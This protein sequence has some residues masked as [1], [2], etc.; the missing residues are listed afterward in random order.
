MTVA[1]RIVLF[2]WS[3]PFLIRRRSLLRHPCH[4]PHLSLQIKVMTMTTLNISGHY[5]RLTQ[6]LTP[7]P[8]QIPLHPNPPFHL[9]PHLLANMQT[10]WLLDGEYCRKH[11]ESN[12]WSAHR[13][14]RKELA[15]THS[16]SMSRSTH[17]GSS[18]PLA[19]PS[20]CMHT[21]VKTMN[22][23]KVAYAS[24]AKG[25]SLIQSFTMCWPK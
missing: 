20:C 25:C 2:Q 4:H 11:S 21:S 15:R 5:L 3:P 24:H 7:L 16:F 6:S 9:S 18:P 1:W 13:L 8:K 19:D 22:L 12:I 23:T 10:R 17:H 14:D